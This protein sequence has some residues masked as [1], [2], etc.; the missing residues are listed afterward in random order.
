MSPERLSLKERTDRVRKVM[1][2]PHSFDC[3]YLSDTSRCTCGRD[4]LLVQVLG[5]I[6]DPPPTFLDRDW[7]EK[8]YR[9]IIAEEVAK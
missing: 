4:K 6:Q 7:V 5:D 2:I 3:R 8:A 9:A 1:D